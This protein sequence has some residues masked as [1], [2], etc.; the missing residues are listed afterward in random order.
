MGVEQR[1]H[2]LESQ[3]VAAQRRAGVAA[4]KGADAQAGA[5]VAAT[6]VED[7]AHER[8]NAAEV[9]GTLVHHVAI[10]ERNRPRDLSRHLALPPAR[11]ARTPPGPNRSPGRTVHCKR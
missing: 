8:L 9:D 1:P 2:A 6:L 10:V 3:V 5:T 11:P 4:D 7:E